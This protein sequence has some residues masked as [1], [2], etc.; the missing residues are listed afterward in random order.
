MK[1]KHSLKNAALV[2][3]WLLHSSHV[4]SS[5]FA[6]FCYYSGSLITDSDKTFPCVYTGWR[7]SVLCK[8]LCEACGSAV[9]ERGEDALPGSSCLQPG[10]GRVPLRSVG[11]TERTVQPEGGQ[12]QD[13]PLLQHFS[14][15]LNAC[16][17][18]RMRR[19][20]EMG[21]GPAAAKRSG[22]SACDCQAAAE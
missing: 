14:H 4:F 16:R 21:G 19:S 12:L 7:A 15:L 17:P 3:S 1:Q 13:G 8:C 10:V 2:K 6:N 9:M 20:E 5:L 11:C 22:T 18:T